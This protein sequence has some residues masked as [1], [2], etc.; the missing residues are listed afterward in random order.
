MGYIT[1]LDYARV[2]HKPTG[3]VGMVIPELFGWRWAS[4]QSVQVLIENSGHRHAHV[5]PVSELEVL[6]RLDPAQVDH[7]LFSLVD[8]LPKSGGGV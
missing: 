5:F 2:K 7:N 8:L 4:W 1:E 6:D 3:Q